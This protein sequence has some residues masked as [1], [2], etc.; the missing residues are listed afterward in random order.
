MQTIAPAETGTLLEILPVFHDAL[1]PCCLRPCGEPSWRLPLEAEE[2]I[3]AAVVRHLGAAGIE[4][5][6]VHSTSW[7]QEVG[8][9]VLLTHLAVV[10]PPGGCAGFE[11]WR[12]R[13]RRLARGSAV[14]PPIAIDVEQVV[15]HALRHLAWLVTDDRAIRTAL[16]PA[17]RERLTAYRPEPFSAR[18]ATAPARGG[19][20]G[21]ARPSPDRAPG[22]G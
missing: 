13:R 15:E 1:G 17:W 20:R 3:Q 12:P 5:V 19:R 10:R 4:A 9:A 22:A 2:D 18:L 16:D 21:R 14:G 8:R 6:V 11:R 7:R